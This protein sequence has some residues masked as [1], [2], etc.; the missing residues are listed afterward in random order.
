MA[1]RTYTLTGRQT[2]ASIMVLFLGF[3]FVVCDA[4]RDSSATHYPA[5]T[6]ATVAVYHHQHIHAYDHNARYASCSDTKHDHYTNAIFGGMCP[7]DLYT[8]GTS[9][10]TPHSIWFHIAT[11]SGYGCILIAESLVQFYAWRRIMVVWK[12][13]RSLGVSRPLYVLILREG[14]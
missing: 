2:I 11:Y 1:L 5:L 7:T 4:V 8:S 3:I 14:G 10:N 9:T 6:L 12:C 13:M